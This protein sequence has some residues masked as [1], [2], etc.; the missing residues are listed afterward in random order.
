MADA[1]TLLATPLHSAHVARGARMTA[2]AGYDM[3]VSYPLGVLKEHLWTRAHAGLFDVSHMGPAFLRL[4]APSGDPAADHAAISA[5]I[6]PLVSGDIAGLAPG[7]LRYTLL[8]NE[9][10]GILDDLMIGRPSAPGRQGELYL[11]VNAANKGADF[12]LIAAA[13]GDAAQLVRADDRALIALQ[14]PEAAAVLSTLAPGVERLAFMSFDAFELMGH[15]A[16]IA[17]SG[18]TG[19]DGFEMLISAEGAVKLWAALLA[20]ERVEAIGLGARD[21]LRL[22]AGLPLHG[23]DIDPTTSP[24]EGALGFAVSKK[25]LKAGRL[26]AAA[27]LA[28][29]A[30]GALS[31]VRAGIRV[32][33]GA[34]AREGAEIV[35]PDGEVLGLVT[36]GGFSPSLSAPIAMAYLPPAQAVPGTRLCVRVRGRVQMAEV[37][38]LPFVPQRYFRPS[39]GPMEV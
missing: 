27:R 4:T 19:E 23:H 26:A 31:R 20:D 35:A 24:F 11:V 14:G 15:E 12:A 9:T 10:G 17:R 5:L 30:G 32:L 1:E 7:K 29:E 8:L 2:F 33:E 18:Y 21:S 22:E 34:P 16:L 3:P 25:R 6:E 36:S 37:A 13:V 28:A 39:A 38:A